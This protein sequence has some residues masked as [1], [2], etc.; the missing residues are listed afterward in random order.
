MARSN[1][2]LVWAALAGGCGGMPPGG[3]GVV[4]EESGGT[5]DPAQAAGAVPAF[6]RALLDTIATTEGTYRWDGNDGYDV[7]FTYRTFS[8]CTRHPAQVN[9]SGNLCSDAAGRYQFLSSTW[10]GLGLPFFYP[11]DQ[12]VGAM[13]L[14]NRRG[15]YPPTDRAMT[16]AEFQAAMGTC[17]VNTGGLALEWASLPPGCYGQPSRTMD[18]A[19]AI[20]SSHA[21][22]PP[23]PAAGAPGTIHALGKCADIASSGSASGTHAQIYGCNGTSA[24]SFSLGGA[25]QIYTAFGGCLDVS[26]SNTTDGTKVQEWSCNGTGAQVWSLAGVAILGAVGK[27][28]DVPSNHWAAGQAVQLY[29][30]N[31]TAAQRWTYDP[32]SGEI[33]G[34]NGMCLD[35]YQAVSANGQQVQVYPCHGG[36]N[37]RWYPSGG[38]LHSGIDWGRCLDVN[39]AG[40]A[41]GTKIQIW[42]CNG[43]PAQRFAL[44]GAI[45][46][47]GG[48]CLD[49]PGS[50]TTNGNQLQIWSCNGTGAQNWTFWLPE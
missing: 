39:R 50:N 16:R 12:D 20:Y 30:C 21:S 27:C 5:C 26:R 49:I 8:D 28:V 29:D 18:E 41:N 14:V 37:Q 19:W 47:I 1:H 34:A 31:G 2:L 32:S 10:G 3:D 9:C 4:N 44:A 42:D 6:H 33:Q 23:A 7:E 35:V 25:G 17:D 13:A 45:H 40:T 36:A 22:A 15:V 48:K 38:A 43:T 11:S 46:G 24:Q